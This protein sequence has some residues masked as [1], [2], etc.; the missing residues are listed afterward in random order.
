[1]QTFTHLFSLLRGHP[2]GAAERADKED[3]KGE[4]VEKLARAIVSRRLEAPAVLLLELN[5]PLGFLLSQGAFFARPFVSFFLPPREVEAAAEVLGDPAAFDHLI[6]R[7]GELE[8][9][10][11]N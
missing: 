2:E 7:I 11:K 1:V 4:I 5:R 3:A 10:E 8:P 9:E 6:E